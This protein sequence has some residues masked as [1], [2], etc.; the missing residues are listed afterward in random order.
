[1]RS[2]PYEPIGVGLIPTREKRR[3]YVGQI[4]KSGPIPRLSKIEAVGGDEY[5][6]GVIF[7]DSVHD[8]AAD[9]RAR[10]GWGP[11]S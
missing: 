11:P 10:C 7:T 3:L 6:N 1:M 4:D 2:I 8:D 5:S 9:P